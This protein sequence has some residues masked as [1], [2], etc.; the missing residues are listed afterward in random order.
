MASR[1]RVLDSANRTMQRL[2]YLKALAAIV[3]ESETSNLETLGKKLISRVTQRARL[4]PPFDTD[5]HEYAQRRL[6]DGSYKELRAR[7][8]HNSGPATVELQDVYLAD[9]SLPSNTGKQL[10]ANWRRYPYLGT[11]LELIKK[12]TY[13]AMTRSLVL[14]RAYD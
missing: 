10:D 8:L 13:S 14:L 11:S 1:I 5:L 9:P 3:N 12:G 7:I 4:V 2:G 6:T